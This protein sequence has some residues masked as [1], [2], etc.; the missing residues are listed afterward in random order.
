MQQS[1]DEFWGE[2]AASIQKQQQERGKKFTAAMLKRL[3]MVQR[4]RRF[5][6]LLAS[7][8]EVKQLV[9]SVFPKLGTLVATVE[10]TEEGLNAFAGVL[11]SGSEKDGQPELHQA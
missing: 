8:D 6:T 2:H 4:R 10:Y 3:E 7:D 1:T 9:G 11:S 5:A